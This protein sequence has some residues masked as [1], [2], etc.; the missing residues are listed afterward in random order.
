MEEIL[1]R[2]GVLI[3]VCSSCKG[4]YL[5]QGELNFFVRNRKIL[6]QYE[7]NGLEAAHDIAYKCPKCPAGESK[8][9]VGRIPG[10]P[11]QVEECGSCRGIFFDAHEFKKIQ[12]A[13][14]FRSL[15][16]DS[17]VSLKKPVV[18]LA[19]PQ[20]AGAP[21]S[22]PDAASR[23]AGR[24]A[25][26]AAPVKIPSLGLTTAAV[27]LGLYGI[28]F[29][30]IVFF[31]ELGYLSLLAGSGAVLAFAAAQFYF[32]PL[33][34]DWQLRLIGSLE[35][36]P[37]SR[38]PPS[39]KSA[40]ERLCG[41]NRLP[42]P[43]V[44]IINDSSPAAYTYGRTPR[45]ARLVFSRGMFE[46]LD[47]DETEAVL[48][49]ELGHIKNW[50]FAIMAAIKVVPLLL[51]I[52]YRNIKSSMETAPP[53]DKKARA[54]ALVTAYLFYLISEYL[55]LFVS[56]V[57]EYAADK[58]SC[59]ASKKPNALLT[60][61]VKISYGLLSAG[62]STSQA[63]GDSS[64]DSSKDSKKKSSRED[65]LRS[66]EALNILSLSR[67]KQIALASQGEGEDSRFSPEAIQDIMRW[68]LWSPW[69]FYYE[70]HSTHPLTAKRI[71]AIGSYALAMG[72]KPFLSF[73]RQKPESYWDDFFLD[74]F[75][76]MLPF[77]L[78]AG[79]VL[80][81]LWLGGMDFGGLNVRDMLPS[82]ESA[83]QALTLKKPAMGYGPLG[84][85]LLGLSIGALIRLSRSYPFGR[86]RLHSVSSLLKLIKV[87]PVR[88]FP[89]RLRGRIL[90]RGE[91]GQLFSEDFVMKDKT[92]IIYLNHEPFGLNILFA[93]F[94]YK[95]F[96]GRQVSVTG[97][98]RRSPSPYLEVRS[99]Q[100]EGA[101]PSDSARQA[102]GAPPK[103]EKSWAYTFHYK[104]AF[105][106]LGA[107]AG[108][109]LIFL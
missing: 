84:F 44:G 24:K 36:T 58:F 11:F 18:R 93:L 42:L 62:A 33:L 5:D 65:R 83:E 59:Y 47:E 3:D 102:A 40:L 32:G 85:G 16:R 22:R 70:I 100:T 67:S 92:G 55:V 51:Y 69:A 79:G 96:Q 39:F 76:L 2:R 25:R 49:H 52:L 73:D 41:E 108:G 61:L 101:G 21:G 46:L 14:E 9:R 63:G 82:A 94:R 104:L 29:A 37:L 57:R 28:L 60:A 103:E 86:F 99:I 90:G 23:G 30:A 71:N 105:C 27:C 89:V 88:S 95:K 56:R 53:K 38:L 45:S 75:V 72:Q 7:T 106:L 109:A 66:M 74:I 19:S 97:W 26:P 17:S 80:S 50:D 68:D 12:S 77:I 87:S 15:R 35:W 98:Y 43:K 107:L 4:V 78:A 31:V 20:K 10:F 6:L 1:T 13:K 34:M 64:E 54:A 91:A 81:F 8:M 48:A